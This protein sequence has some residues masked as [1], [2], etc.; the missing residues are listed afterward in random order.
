MNSNGTDTRKLMPTSTA[1]ICPSSFSGSAFGESKSTSTTLS[2]NV[3]NS[4]R[5]WRMANG[6]PPTAESSTAAAGLT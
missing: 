6:A 5:N 3:R 2:K 1:T 4:I